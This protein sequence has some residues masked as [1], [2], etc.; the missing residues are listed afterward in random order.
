M[1]T[2]LL[3]SLQSGCSVDADAWRKGALTLVTVG[4]C[5][6]MYDTEQSFVHTWILLLESH[7]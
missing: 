3:A 6:P 4:T 1:R 5:D 7:L 2:E